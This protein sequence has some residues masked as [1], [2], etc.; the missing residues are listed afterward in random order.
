[1]MRH[2]GQAVRAPV[3]PEHRP[4][5]EFVLWHHQWVFKREA[6]PAASVAHL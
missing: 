2:H 6:R 1:L 5:L 4:A 3:R